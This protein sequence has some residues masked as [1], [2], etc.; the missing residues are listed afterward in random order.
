MCSVVSVGLSFKELVESVL[1]CVTNVE[2][3]VL[4]SY[5]TSRI[6]LDRELLGL[7]AN[8][9]WRSKQV[10]HLL[11]HK[12]QVRRL[13]MQTYLFVIDLDIT[14]ANGD[15]LVELAADF[16][17]HLLDGPRN[18]TSLLVVIGEAQHRK[19]L[20]SSSLTVGHDGSIVALDNALDDTC[21]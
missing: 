16:V 20:S 1:L 14:D 4:N 13:K 10:D 11:N 9:L 2:R 3:Q 19:G 7:D 8:V 5:S 18:D 15:G 21:G 6:V 12:G 17:V